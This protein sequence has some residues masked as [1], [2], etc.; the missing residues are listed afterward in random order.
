MEEPRGEGED[1]AIHNSCSE[2]LEAMESKVEQ[3][4]DKGRKKGKFVV[5]FNANVD[6]TPTMVMVHDYA[7]IRPY[8]LRDRKIEIMSTGGFSQLM[9]RG[10]GFVTSQSKP[11][12]E[13]CPFQGV[14]IHTCWKC[15]I[16]TA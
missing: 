2:F 5:L 13:T 10:T 16:A 12:R 1:A 15:L 11:F 8:T 9:R 4:M 7:K 3:S 6:G 14:Q